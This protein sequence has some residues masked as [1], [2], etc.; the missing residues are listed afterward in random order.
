MWLNVIDLKISWWMAG[1][2]V[3][4]QSM[5]NLHNQYQNVSFFYSYFSSHGYSIKDGRTRHF[6]WRMWFL[7]YKDNA[8]LH[9]R[10]TIIIWNMYFQRY[11]EKNLPT[12]RHKKYTQLNYQKACWF[13]LCN[14]SCQWALCQMQWR[15]TVSCALYLLEET[16]LYLLLWI[17]TKQKAT[18]LAVGRQNMARTET[19]QHEQE[20]L[21]G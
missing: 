16:L 18:I 1:C 15:M 20:I 11:F 3:D 4:S 6:P 5:R 7:C 14:L 21:P 9:T 10:R 19:Q 2:Q 17:S 13:L 12:H 8:E